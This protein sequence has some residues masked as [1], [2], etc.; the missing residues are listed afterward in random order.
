MI[1]PGMEKPSLI[2]LKNM[3]SSFQKIFLPAPF[4]WEKLTIPQEYG[5][6]PGRRE[7]ENTGWR[8][9]GHGMRKGGTETGEWSHSDRRE[10]PAIGA[11]DEERS[12]YSAGSFSLFSKI[13]SFM[14][15][16]PA[17]IL[18]KILITISSS[19]IWA[20]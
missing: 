2:A 15:V 11:Q 13:N 8:V 16:C 14:L 3:P 9:M 6:S 7:S 18:D 4:P 19:G 20:V 17:F 10:L 5:A 12:T 1:K